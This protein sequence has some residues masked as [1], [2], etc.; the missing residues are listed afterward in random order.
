M[1]VG[2]GDGTGGVSRLFG[3]GLGGVDDGKE[4]GE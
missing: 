2:G 4:L 3:A 1:G